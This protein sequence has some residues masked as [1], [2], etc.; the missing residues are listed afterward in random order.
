MHAGPGMRSGLGIRNVFG[1]HGLGL[2]DDSGASYDIDPGAD[3]F[4]GI[5]YDPS[6]IDPTL[7]SVGLD[8]SPPG[9]AT[10]STGSGSG[11]TPASIAAAI[12]AAANAATGVYRA[13]S[14]PS[15]IPGTNAIY[16]PAT[17]QITNAGL[18]STSGLGAS[19]SSMLPLLLL[20]G[21]GLLLVSAM[22]KGR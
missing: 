16:N 21:G 14:S 17:G 10:T 1:M 3:P 5:N 13:T 11:V 4:S 2:G 7:L 8:T 18:L 19:L 15:V 20:V 6:Q 12:A 9:S 22:G